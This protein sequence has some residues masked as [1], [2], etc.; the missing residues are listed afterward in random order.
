VK[1]HAKAASA[2]PTSGR[3]SRLGS[4]RRAF[5]CRGLSSDAD[6]SGAPSGSRL[7]CALAVLTLAL[8][9]IPASAFA[10][11]TR[12]PTAFSPIT[13]T[14]AGAAFSQTPADVAVDQATG[15]V[16]VLVGSEVRIFNSEG[17][18]PVGVAP[19]YN[20]TVLGFP[21][22]IEIDN[23]ATSPNKGSLYVASTATVHRFTRNAGTEKYEAA[24]ELV[25]TSAL[26]DVEDIAV[27]THG[28]VFVNCSEGA[29]SCARTIVKFGPTG[30][31]LRRFPSMNHEGNQVRTGH[32]AVDAAGDVFVSQAEYTAPFSNVVLKYP[33]DGSG[34][35]DPAAVE[36]VA[37]P[38]FGGDHTYYGPLAVDTAA[39]QIYV[40]EPSRQFFL[41]DATSL[42]KSET[43]FGGN[44]LTQRGRFTINSLNSLVYAIDGNKVV[45]FGAE[46]PL[47]TVFLQGATGN[48]GTKA[49]LNA[50]VNG[51]GAE[52][53]ECRFEY[54]ITT[55][56]GT[57]KPCEG[58][59]PADSSPHPV[60]AQLS[61]LIPQGQTYHFRVVAENA[62][63]T[64]TEDGSFVTAD[65]FSTGDATGVT[66][67]SATLNGSVRPEGFPLS[68]CKFEYGLT[69]DYGLSI[70]CS[71]SA[72]TIAGDFDSHAVSATPGSLQGNA[73]Y[74]FRISAAGGIGSYK[75]ADKTFTTLGGPLITEQAVGS[76][77][78]TSATLYGQVNPRGFNTNFYFEYGTSAAYGSK[79][80]VD[81]DIF[82]GSGTE[83]VKGFQ[84]VSGLQ[85]NTTY[86]Y[87]IV[88]IS[89]AGT[90]ISP[91][92]TFT[93]ARDGSS[94]P[95]AAVRAEQ[96]TI[97]SPGLPDCRAIEMVN[98]PQKENQFAR[99]PAVSADGERVR[100]NSIAALGGTPNSLN[101]V[102]GDPYVATRTA[103]GWVTS[104]T[105]PPAGFNDGWWGRT[106][107]VEAVS[108]TPDYSHWLQIASTKGQMERGFGA[109]YRG[110]IGG[111]F[112]QLS[113]LL[114]P[115][116]GI[117]TPAI[118]KNSQLE[119]A[120]PD[121]SVLYFK[122]GGVD[123]GID[124]SY[125]AG[126]P[127]PAG[128]VA[129]PNVYIARLDSGSEPSLTLL[130]RDS[131]GKAWG[132]NCGVR[133]GS[134][135]VR[136]GTSGV[137]RN[138]G[139]VSPDGSRVYFSTRPS[140][141]EGGAC[142]P[143]PNKMRVL[144]RTET[145]GGI[146]IEELAKNE[147]D[148]VTPAC[149][150]AD[151][152]DLYQGA[153][154]DQ[155]KVYFTT[156]RQLSDSDLDTGS[157]CSTSVGASAGCDLYLR[158]DELPDGEQLIQVS[159]GEGPTPGQGAKVLGVTA[160]SGDGSHVY[161][162]ATGV[163]TT[164]P[165]A[166]GDSARAG[167]PNLYLYVRDEEY[168]DGHT[169]FVA[170]LDPEES[171]GEGSGPTSQ[172]LWGG[173]GAWKSRAYPVPVTGVDGDGNEVGGDGR[174][175]LF[176]TTAGLTGG[177]RD[178][179]HL[180]V[181]RYDSGTGALLCV[182]C[183]PGGNDAGAFDVKARGGGG[184]LYPVSADFAE[185]ER[186]VSEDGNTVVF[187]TRAGLL[188]E[189]QNGFTDS[190][191]W[192]EGQLNLLPG[193]ADSNVGFGTSLFDVP[194][195]SHDGSTVAFTSFEQLLPQDGDTA[196]NTYVARV[197]GGYPEPVPHV[198]CTGEACQQP[199]T[200]EPGP[201]GP[202]ASGSFTGPGNV[203][204][205]APA[206]GKKHKARKHKK[207]KKNNKQKH[208]RRAGHEQ[209]GQK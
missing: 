165:N 124:T 46:V 71:P 40:P 128:V 41:Y 10:A 193:T 137:F 157:A 118:I 121:A 138:Q 207:H 83:D 103:S 48:T 95:N 87:R 30:T 139:V 5:A 130:A 197:N 17:G 133:I 100:F 77:A 89:T 134:V 84:K 73:T 27:D 64:T 33:V 86:H 180:D 61:G 69:A 32:L 15:N 45:V 43:T 205:K 203:K 63:G 188:P 135:A 149:S 21:S 4:V 192:R 90:N 105:V 57:V 185:D 132:G 200:G 81:T 92:Q 2:G 163:L 65:I 110:G 13:G 56:Y 181:Y 178:G 141:I 168:P 85:G 113:P 194:V 206:K 204:A 70:P 173:S 126:D 199:F 14:G 179:S 162:A 107:T 50:T 201:M 183:A 175:L 9:L 91:D 16:F 160:I 25:G 189:D 156:P 53:D 191:L 23:S 176:Q 62:N 60:S 55:S 123:S 34:E 166:V 202:A 155:S 28:N 6:G 195:L 26:S 29:S 186:W 145:P 106:G 42:A 93:T 79:A 170:T 131:D 76:V 143:D 98:P 152:D 102:S 31:E 184:A 159:A 78:Q 37:E 75:G 169:A 161:F 12:K 136:D 147:C 67:A 8:V 150:A 167:S 18:V 109:A 52:V 146:E 140:Q 99:L 208:S 144:V 7:L 108:F 142:E 111:A 44:D 158:D 114:V 154:V 11:N 24:G 22:S 101:A 117:G 198:P 94:C 68:E 74:H 187:T 190:Y 47:P 171:S 59:I 36:V 209:G 196:I 127:V 39:N 3:G 104:P 20:V 182:S 129:D 58:A 120:T 97:G 88:A 115:V 164:V 177:D 96:A 49:K 54:G 116:E 172:R 125:L 35:A 72:A 19:P 38:V 151:G 119:A 66:N 174:I 122:P 112:L 153:S 1:R 51:L 148:R 82:V 80:P